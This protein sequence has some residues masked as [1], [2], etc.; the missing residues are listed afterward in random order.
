MPSD[1][2]SYCLLSWARR[3]QPPILFA[4]KSSHPLHPR[5]RSSSVHPVSR[6]TISTSFYNM[7]AQAPAQTWLYETPQ[8]QKSPIHH[9]D[10]TER[11]RVKR[12]RRVDDMETGLC[13]PL[14][15]LRCGEHEHPC[16]DHQEFISSPPCTSTTERNE[17]LLAW[18]SQ[19]RRACIVTAIIVVLV[20]MMTVTL[21]ILARKLG[22]LTNI[23]ASTRCSL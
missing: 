9:A 19:F 21:L 6:F 18:R 23:S 15:N 5:V 7:S 10:R 8:Y 17:C 14:P 20:F 1:A 4:I 11:K 22:A 12:A 13:V 3:I 16:P 2:I